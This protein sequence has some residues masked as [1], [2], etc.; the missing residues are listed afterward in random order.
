MKFL[1]LAEELEIK[2]ILN[3]AIDTIPDPN[4]TLPVEEN[5]S[6]VLQSM[7]PPGSPPVS[8]SD[9]S[10]ERS[11]RYTTC[12]ATAASAANAQCIEGKEKSHLKPVDGMCRYCSC[13]SIDQ[14]WLILCVASISISALHQRQHHAQ[15]RTLLRI[16][17]KP[18]HQPLSNLQ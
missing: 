2:G 9:N 6:N 14:C 17:S 12:A 13:V 15:P 7:H 4:S 16:E 8:T 3:H 1:K 10:I 5:N 18:L 11:R